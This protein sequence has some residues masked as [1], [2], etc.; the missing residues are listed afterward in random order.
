[1]ERAQQAGAGDLTNASAFPIEDWMR[2]H[3][4]VA[5]QLNDDVYPDS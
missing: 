1:M 2:K 5:V 4:D 3:Q